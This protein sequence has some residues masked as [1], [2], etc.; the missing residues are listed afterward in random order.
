MSM[1]AF[2]SIINEAAKAGEATPPTELAS[3]PPTPSPPIRVVITSCMAYAPFTVPH[4]VT[5]LVASGVPSEAIHVVVGESRVACDVVQHVGPHAVAYHYVPYCNIDN[6]GL[7]W[8]T[9]R[10]VVPCDDDGWIM[11]LHDTCLV[12]PHFWASC[13][14][15]IADLAGDA[16]AVRM[17]MPFSMGIGFY[18]LA[19]LRTP[20][21]RAYMAGLRN[22][23]PT[24]IK[25]VK[26]NLY[27]LE[28]TLF[29]YLAA[30]DDTKLKALK[31]KYAL[32]VLESNPY[33]TAT[34]RAVEYYATPGVYKLKANW[35]PNGPF[36]T[37]L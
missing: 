34:P 25:D 18:R 5:S 9:Q 19:W 1:S 7:M 6:N 22:D 35:N 27:V 26:S 2:A 30:N 11:Y 31:N 23:D 13:R 20:E 28:D 37:D 4:L 8:L 29:K 17:H 3:E 21:V 32:R 15:V 36:V 16:N 10:D 24:K 33:G 14:R 12:A